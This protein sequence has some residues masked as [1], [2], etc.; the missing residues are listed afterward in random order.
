MVPTRRDL[1]RRSFSTRFASPRTSSSKSQLEGTSRPHFGPSTRGGGARSRRPAAVPGPGL[2]VPSERLVDPLGLNLAF[3]GLDAD[4]RRA[5]RLGPAARVAHR[6][7][8]VGKEVILGA[9]LGGYGPA[10]HRPRIDDEDRCF[11]HLTE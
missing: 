9:A 8:L 5:V 4:A 6:H 2:A 3:A 7:L 10:V 1:S 11:T